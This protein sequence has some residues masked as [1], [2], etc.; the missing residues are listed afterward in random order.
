MDRHIAVRAE[1]R[2][3]RPYAAPQIADV[4]RLNTNENPYPP[5]PALVADMAATVAE[6]ASS[7]HRY[8]DREATAL[9]ADL[10]R[11]V[12][13]ATGVALGVENIW[14]ANGS[15]EIIQQVLQA[16]GG[17][18]RTVMGF[19]P[20]YDMYSRIAVGTATSWV[21]APRRDDLT[22]DVDAAEVQLRLHQPDITLL[23]SPN[24]PTGQSL[25][26][27][28]L[29]R[30][31]DATPG[32]VI[33]D[34]A[35]GEYSTRPSAANL[36]AT[37]GPRLLVTRT[38]SKALAFAGARLGYLIAAP[39]VVQALSL[40]TL[41]YHLSALTQA[42]A[43]AALRHTDTTLASVAL[44]RAERERVRAELTE[45]GYDVTPSDANFLLLGTFIDAPQAWQTFL[46]YGVLIRDVGIPG[47]LRTTIGTT[48]ENDRLLAVART[49]SAR[50]AHT[51]G[52]YASRDSGPRLLILPR[53]A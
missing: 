3:A 47:R 39:E 24:N 29:A 38:I 4:V 27:Q 40:V 26:L 32:V 12:L 37:Y 17:P 19:L 23:T 51:P 25:S 5:V 11:Y 53:T 15:L 20:T 41:P 9:R 43:R 22:L 31:I 18:G 45:A 1:L 16:F 42:V 7:L 44:V 33:V 2:A 8:P 50:S 21:S 36:L 34:E 48:E 35:Y 6:A 46:D 28:Q 10:A 30:L 14:P 49:I 52:R 13:D